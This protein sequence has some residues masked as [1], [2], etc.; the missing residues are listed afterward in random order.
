MF[1]WPGRLP[2]QAKLL[3]H[4][5]LAGRATEIY[6]VSKSAAT[7]IVPSK[8]FQVWIDVETKLPAKIVVQNTDPKSEMKIVWL[9]KR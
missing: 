8:D 4:E 2:D 1:L 3:G 6:Q 9:A 5:R 7:G